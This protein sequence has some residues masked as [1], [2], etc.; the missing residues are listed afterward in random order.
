MCEDAFPDWK[1]MAKPKPFL[2][3]SWEDVYDKANVLTQERLRRRPTREEITEIFD[4]FDSTDVD[5]EYDTFWTK[6]EACVIAYYDE[7][8]A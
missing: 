2:M 8:E 3:L 6:V 5:C 7:K 1:D 4:S